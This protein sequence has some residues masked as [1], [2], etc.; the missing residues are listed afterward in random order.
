MTA[1]IEIA[2]NRT[3]DEYGGTLTSSSIGLVSFP[4]DDPTKVSAPNPLDYQTLLTLK[5]FCDSEIAKAQEYA[6]AIG[7]PPATTKGR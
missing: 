4:V 3:T 6:A 2:V 7:V 1:R 5:A